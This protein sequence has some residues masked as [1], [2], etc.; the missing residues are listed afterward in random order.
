MQLAAETPEIYE[1]L[2]AERSDRAVAV[3]AAAFLSELLGSLLRARFI[4]STVTVAGETRVPHE[5]AIPLLH[6]FE[7]R[8]NLCHAIGLI[9]PGMCADLLAINHVRNHLGHRRQK[10][11]FA[12]Q[13]VAKHI[14]FLRDRRNAMLPSAGP[15]N[16]RTAFTIPAVLAM[17]ELLLTGLALKPLPPGK[18]LSL[19]QSIALP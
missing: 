10:A 16:E 11:G 4:T 17:N 14:A 12:D 18:D 15:I 8:I 3:I 1:Q 9:G 5:R 13:K 7:A 2:N 19:R 6:N